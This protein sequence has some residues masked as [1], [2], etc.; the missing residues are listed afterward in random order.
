MNEQ[1]RLKIK[2]PESQRR[3][4]LPRQPG[5]WPAPKIVPELFSK[6]PSPKSLCS[7]RFY[8]PTVSY[9]KHDHPKTN[10]CPLNIRNTCFSIAWRFSRPCHCLAIADPNRQ[11]S[12]NRQLCSQ[13]GPDRCLGS[14]CQEPRSQEM[15][16]FGAPRKRFVNSCKFDVFFLGEL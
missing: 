3:P 6:F 14:W 11:K 10:S 2:S 12:H 9:K 7:W 5:E 8:N 1:S 13:V 15:P 16:L 4:R